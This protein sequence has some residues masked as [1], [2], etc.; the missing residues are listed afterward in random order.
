MM[1]NEQTTLTIASAT[2]EHLSVSALEEVRAADYNLSPSQFV[3]VGERMTH[4][5]VSEILADLDVAKAERE[6]ADAH[7]ADVLAR[8]GLAGGASY[9]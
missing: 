2:S 6:Q 5:P 9:A 1:P 3:G 4:E 7:L 8:L